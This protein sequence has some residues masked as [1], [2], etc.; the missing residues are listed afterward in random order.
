MV[1]LR[2]KL[3]D[4]LKSHTARLANRLAG[5]GSNVEKLIMRQRKENL[6][7]IKERYVELQKKALGLPAKEQSKALPDGDILK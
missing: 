1:G 5:K 2:N 7:I 4:H 6:T 3:L